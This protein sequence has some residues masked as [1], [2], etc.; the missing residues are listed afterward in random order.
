MHLSK[1]S[2]PLSASASDLLDSHSASDLLDSQVHAWSSVSPVPDG[3]TKAKG[4]DSFLYMG[5]INTRAA[6]ADSAGLQRTKCSGTWL[7][8][9]VAI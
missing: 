4:D 3:P 7:P 6:R 8:I 9:D 5:Q 2:W 1:R